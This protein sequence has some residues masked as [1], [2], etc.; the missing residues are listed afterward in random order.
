[1]KLYRLIAFVAALAITL[2]VASFPAFML[3]AAAETRGSMA[4]V[5]HRLAVTFSSFADP[6]A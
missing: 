2:L 4:R 3:T 1:M 6:R 5:E